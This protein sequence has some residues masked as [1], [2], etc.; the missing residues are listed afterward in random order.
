MDTGA[1]S[2]IILDSAWAAGNDFARE[3]PLIKTIVLTNPRGIQFKTQVVQAPALQLN[4]FEL[5]EVPALILGTKNPA[6]FP[7][8]NLGN[9]VLKRFNMILD[10]RN[11]LVYWKPN[12]LFPTAFRTDRG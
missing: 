11:D 7:I 2:A 3:L 9:D 5:K 8:N 10:F 12:S 1:E 4:G 6:G